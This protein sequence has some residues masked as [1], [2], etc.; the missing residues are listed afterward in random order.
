MAFDERTWCSSAI[1]TCRARSWAT[2]TPCATGATPWLTIENEHRYL[3]N[4]GS[5]GQPRDGDPRAALP[6][7]RRRRADARARAR[8]VRRRRPRWSG[9]APRACR[10][11]SAERLRWG[12]YGAGLHARALGIVLEGHRRHRRA[13][14]RPAAAWCARS[15]ATARWRARAC[16]RSAR[17]RARLA[18]ARARGR[19]RASCSTTRRPRWRWC[20]EQARRRA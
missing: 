13:R 11:S 12:E 2:A 9:S 18:R 16:S 1:P 10:R 8:R 20:A 14:T 19:D 7:R 15:R 17:A 5:V 4:A 6:A 3:V